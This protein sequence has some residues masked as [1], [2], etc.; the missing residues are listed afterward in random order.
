MEKKE[1]NN[2]PTLIQLFLYFL[3]IGLFTFGG[4]YAIIGTLEKE[5]VDEK[6]WITHEDMLNMIVIG[7]S[8]P[9]PIAINLATFI[10]HKMHGFFGAL[11][12]TVGFIVP[13][14][15]IIVLISL[16][17]QYIK[18]VPPVVSWLFKGIRAGVVVLIGNAAVKFFKRMDKKILSF[19][20]FLTGFFV[21]FF[22]DFS[23]IYLI[24]IGAAIGLIWV[25]MVVTNEKHK[26]KKVYLETESSEATE[27][28]EEVKIEEPV[29]DKKEEKKVEESDPSKGGEQ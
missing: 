9:G 4:G 12:C 22:T 11:L 18:D 25:F 15:V 21:S 3:K 1:I 26:K 13:S 2:K 10:G 16:G 20:L 17:I 27:T 28:K 24:L 29:E 8:T 19:L 23:V 5:L 6:H 14:F 7:E